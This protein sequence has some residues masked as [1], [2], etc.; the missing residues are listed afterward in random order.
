MNLK[1]FNNL[2]DFD[3]SNFFNTIREIEKKYRIFKM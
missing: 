2:K 3:Q 1:L